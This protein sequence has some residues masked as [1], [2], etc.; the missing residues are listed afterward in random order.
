MAAGRAEEELAEEA[1]VVAEEL[2]VVG[3]VAG[4][5]ETSFGHGADG[6]AEER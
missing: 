3:V 1:E 6:G 4:R 5:V 2:G